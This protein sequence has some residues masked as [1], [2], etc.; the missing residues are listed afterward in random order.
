M[1]EQINNVDGAFLRQPDDPRM[2]PEEYQQGQKEWK[3]YLSSRPTSEGGAA[4]AHHPEDGHF[5]DASEHFDG[6]RTELEEDGEESYEDM[7]ISKLAR[8]LAQAEF[9]GDRT[10]QD[11]IS[12]VLDS[13]LD[14]L[15]DASFS[16]RDTGGSSS[17]RPENRSKNNNDL[18]SEKHDQWVEKIKQRELERLRAEQAEQTEQGQHDGD[19]TGEEVHAEEGNTAEEAAAEDEQ[20]PVAPEAGPENDDKPED[21]NTP[22]VGEADPS[23]AKTEVTDENAGEEA[24]ESDSEEAGS[25]PESAEP[26]EEP[27]VSPTMAESID[28]NLARWSKQ[29]SDSRFVPSPWQYE[30]LKRIAGQIELRHFDS[31]AD[32][33]SGMGYFVKGSDI[34]LNPTYARTVLDKT[35]TSEWVFDHDEYEETKELQQDLEKAK[36]PEDVREDTF[37]RTSRSQVMTYG[38]YLAAEQKAKPETEQNPDAD[39]AEENALRS[40]HHYKHYVKKRLELDEYLMEKY[41]HDEPSP[42]GMTPQAIEEFNAEKAIKAGKEAQRSG[43]RTFRDIAIGGLHLVAQRLHE[44]RAK[45]RQQQEEAEQ[46]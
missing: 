44:A 34:R 5:I 10:S 2:T 16:G 23:E 24:G 35:N 26:A 4:E 12:E 30:T 8:K 42:R 33:H 15:D 38:Q 7:Q 29:L 31:E 1:S 3:E 6:R 18:R 28:K 37:Q 14:D 17:T 43:R 13:K 36:G 45:R 27:E 22:N 41:P 25:Q 39:K 21:G 9:T 20:A 32:G 19:L 46:N 11:S 40:F